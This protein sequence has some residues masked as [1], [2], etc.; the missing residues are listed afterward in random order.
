MGRA[1]GG[2]RRGLGRQHDK[3]NRQRKTGDEKAQCQALEGTRSAQTWDLHLIADNYR[4]RC[5]YSVQEP[6]ISGGCRGRYM[7]GIAG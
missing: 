7:E 2:W 1:S 4:G 6:E 3:G 5:E